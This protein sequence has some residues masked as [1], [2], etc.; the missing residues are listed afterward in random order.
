M[1]QRLNRVVI[2]MNK[3]DIIVK[4]A[5]RI[6]DLFGMYIIQLRRVHDVKSKLL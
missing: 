1:K 4:K 5:N 6:L 3:C 2:G